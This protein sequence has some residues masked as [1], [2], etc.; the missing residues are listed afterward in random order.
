[1]FLNRL[2]Q[3]AYPFLDW[4]QVEISSFCNCKCAYCPHTEYK[5]HWQDRYLP[6]EFFHNLIPAFAKTKLVHLQGWGE[7]FT[8]PHFFELLR[9]AKKAGCMVGTTTNGTILS[10][11]NIKKLIN[12][13][14]DIIAFSLAGVDEKNDSIR[15]GA[16]IK[17]VLKCIEQIH[18]AKNSYGTDNPDIHIAYML[19]RSGLDNLER[20]PPF[21]GNAGISQTVISS[22]SLVVNPVLEAESVL[23][24]GKT[25]FLE[26]KSRLFQVRE[27]SKNRGTDVYFHIVSPLMKGSY[28]SENIS[29][30]VVVGSDGSVS[31]CVMAQI[32]VEGNSFYYFR[33]K[34]HIVRKLAF[35]NIGDE[36]LNTI[37]H[38]K[39]HKSFIRSFI[40]GEVPAFCQNCFKRFI[41]P[42]QEESESNQRIGG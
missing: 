23:A 7:P 5:E 13:G 39:E 15:K 22:L 4:I 2:F 27:A 38:R 20:L 9:F 10:S 16:Q 14:L 40:R 30:A 34:R 33:G 29:R 6:M 8:Y 18:R 1:M 12:E 24:S 41:D 19:L 17:K 35:G 31:P 37:W 36:P 25:E 26:L 3:K 28:C 21:L 11:E 42:L 32:P